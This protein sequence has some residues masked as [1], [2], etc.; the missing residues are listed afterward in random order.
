MGRPF[1][2]TKQY[3]SSDL[4]IGPR[5]KIEKFNITVEE[6][7][8]ALIA[9]GYANLLQTTACSIIDE[10]ETLNNK[11]EAAML[12]AHM[13]HET[14]GFVFKEE[15]LARTDPEK[16]RRHYMTANGKRGKSYHGRGYIMLSYPENYLA[17]SKGLDLNDLLLESPEMVS[18]D[19][20]LC[21][22][23]AIWYWNNV[24][25]KSKNV[26]DNNF[27]ASTLEINGVIE[28]SGEGRIL[29][30]HRLELYKKIASV[31]KIKKIARI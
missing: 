24:V 1:S 8:N 22:K 31:F 27:N 30:R 6:F 5:F 20:K 14:G 13:V 11:N 3:F 29:A 2:Q 18:S 28:S 10:L 17:A 19:E 4:L 9:C 15:E 26:C 25:K 23:T 21:I 7:N 16:A 12:L